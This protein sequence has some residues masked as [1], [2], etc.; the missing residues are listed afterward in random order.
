VDLSTF[1]A[2]VAGTCFTLVGLWWNVVER[3]QEW[4]DDA[5]AR[6]RA[7]GIYLSFLLPGLMSVLAQIDP[8]EPVIW[9]GSFALAGAV[10]LWSTIG[11]MRGDAT[12]GGGRFSANRWV[13]L[14]LYALVATLATA[15]QASAAIGLEP[16]Q[17]GG[18]LL[19]LLIAVAHGL[20]WEFM[21]DR[22]P[23]APSTA[24]G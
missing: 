22:P 2:I 24:D 20:T 5:A 11:L 14:I 17:V 9:R 7:G 19:V 16:L 21:L 1:Y 13:V 18:L 6:R 23:V 12:H 3:H 10:G 4:K 15:P 8:T